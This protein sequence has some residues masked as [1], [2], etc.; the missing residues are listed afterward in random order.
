MSVAAAIAYS[1]N[2][3]TARFAQRLTADELAAS[4][5]TYGFHV[6]GADIRLMALG[7]EGVSTV[8]FDLAQAYRRLADIAEPEVRAGLE[9]AVQFGTARLAAVAGLHVAG[10]TGSVITNNGL[11]AALFAGFEPCHKP[12]YVVTVVTQGRSGGADAA[13]LAAELFRRQLSLK[14]AAA[15]EPTYRV[16]IGQAVSALTVE[17][18]VAAVLA[19][20]ASVFQQAE[21]LKAMAVAARTYAANQKGRHAKDGYDFC[22]TTHCQRAEPDS[23]TPQFKQIAKA[24]QGEVLRF[25]NSPAFTP[26]TMSCGGTTESGGAVWPDLVTPYLPVQHDQY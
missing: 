25:H 21:A 26:Y 22:N 15:G 3:A 5:R 4:L 13:P 24:T 14:P 18:Y 12:E 19:G 1:C 16:R 10:K 8:P 20:E 2:C 9:G 23:V 6:V 7:E 11:H 17:E